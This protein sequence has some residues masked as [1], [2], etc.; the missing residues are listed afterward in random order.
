M[1]QPRAV[2]RLVLPPLLALVCLA[3]APQAL[4]SFGLQSFEASFNEAPPASAEPGALGPP[5]VQAGS[6]PFQVTTSFG[7]TQT[8]N[9]EGQPVPDGQLKD[10]HIEL[11]PGLIGN[12][13]AVP[14]CP[15]E[16]L[17][18]GGVLF[19]EGCPAST[20]IGTLTLNATFGSVITPVFNLVPSPGAPA[21]FGFNLIAPSVMDVAV[22]NESDFGITVSFHNLSQVLP[23][24]GASL[25]LWGVPAAPAHDPLRGS[26]LQPEGGSSGQC[27]TDAVPRPFMT[28]PTSCN[29]PLR[30]AI[31]VES[32]DGQDSIDEREAESQPGD[33][34]ESGLR[35]C[36]RLGF[37]PRIDVQPRVREADQPTDLLVDVGVP[38]K[39]D[40]NGLA[41]ANLK[42]AVIDLP[43][44]LSINPAVAD[45]LVGCTPAQIGL[46]TTALPNC[47]DASTIGAFELD[48]PLLTHPLSG[49]IYLAQPRA[50]P[51]GERMAI[52]A[53]AEEDGI[54]ARLP[55][56]IVADETT[57]QLSISLDVPELPFSNLRLQLFGGPRAVL[58]TPARCGSFTALSRLTP[59]SAP[60]T[61]APATPSV[62][63]EIG[64]GCGGRF[65][66]SFAAGST[67]ASAG[68][69]TELALR[70]GRAD[71]EQLLGSVATTLPAGLLA[72]LSSVSTCAEGEAAAGTCP[73]SSRVGGAVVAAGAGSHPYHLNG[74]VF[75]TGPYDEAPFGLAIVI[76]GLAGPFDLG[77]I[78]VRAGISVSPVSAQITIQTQSLPTILT[79]IPLRIRSV[80]LSIDRPGF[81]RNPTSCDPRLVDGV[82]TS[83]DG[84]GAPVSAPFK[85]RG[86]AKLP[87]KPSIRAIVGARASRERGANLRLEF[88]QPAGD[89]GLRAVKL[90]LPQQLPI[91]LRTLQGACLD[92]IFESSPDNCPMLSRVGAGFARTPILAHPLR[93]PIFVVSHGDR[94]FP[95]LV[96]VLRGEG[97]TIELGGRTAIHDEVASTVFSLPDVPISRFHLNFPRK[98]L[99]LFG[100]NP[101]AGRGRGFCGGS[102][103]MPTTLLAQ[104]GAKKVRRI[105]VKVRGC[106]D[107]ERLNHPEDGHTRMP[108]ID[109]RRWR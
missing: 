2:T 86:C 1:S 54:V 49:S 38:Q 93:G 74:D 68:Q 107:A 10:A 60:Y 53:V 41:T 108:W 59:Y 14:Q 71:G 66:P 39:E 5:A 67:N 57:G 11:P 91:E 55:G 101:T 79:G 12:P 104:N 23:L 18:R 46:G 4:A 45:G 64:Q 7:V 9:A 58:A 13:N 87:F 33:A 95:S 30:V 25:A 48:T 56:R 21:Q 82:I 103:Q 85:V 51:F 96:A 27:P 73:A 70:F 63:F 44:G 37:A 84:V 61:G 3:M 78:V 6:H 105:K 17:A 32:W 34:M 19:G 98:G 40:P 22:R 81:M 88:A 26:C 77:T 100:A 29:G 16:L 47:P 35:G 80:Q 76:P 62:D 42:N 36:G 20:Q 65:S 94:Q 8:T 83:N 15:R 52:Y 90:E 99:P 75:L 24:F 89:A 50:N 72:R 69:S 102:V 109:R 31:K 43:A 106:R 28:L 92:T 97:V